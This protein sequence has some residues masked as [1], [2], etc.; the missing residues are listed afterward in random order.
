MKIRR[1][2]E[3]A[4]ELEF[5]PPLPPPECS[6]FPIKVKYVHEFGPPEG[7]IP[8]SAKRLPAGHPQASQEPAPLGII[9]TNVLL[10]CT[11]CTD[12]KVQVLNGEWTLEEVR[13]DMSLGGVHNPDAVLSSRP[14]DTKFLNG[15]RD[16]GHTN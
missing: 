16:H 15:P 11:D 8:V 10:Q 2:A 7:L 1:A 5:V 14:P 3:P 13:G 12:V 4:P 6:W 9:A